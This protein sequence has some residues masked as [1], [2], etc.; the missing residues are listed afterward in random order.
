VTSLFPYEKVVWVLNKTD[1]NEKLEKQFDFSEHPFNPLSEPNKIVIVPRNSIFHLLKNEGRLLV[2]YNT[3]KTVEEIIEERK[4][5]QKELHE[6]NKRRLLGEELTDEEQ[7]RIKKL[8]ELIKEALKETVL[9]RE[10]GELYQFIA[11]QTPV[12]LG[13]ENPVIQ[14]L[15][16]LL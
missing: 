14:K 10:V 13:E 4:K 9:K 12:L 1:L 7:L 15:A 2:N 5:Y 16:K 3:D 11:D 8:Q 6:L